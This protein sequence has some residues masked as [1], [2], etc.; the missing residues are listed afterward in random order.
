MPDLNRHSDKPSSLHRLRADASASAD[1]LRSF[2][3]QTRGKSP[4]E[5]IGL[6]AQSNLVVATMQAALACS[7]L[8]LVLTLVPYAL[9]QR[10]DTPQ[11][12][13][14]AAVQ[15]ETPAVTPTAAEPAK[16]AKTTTPEKP[17]TTDPAK[18]AD[19]LGEG[20]TKTGPA[21]EPKIDINDLLDK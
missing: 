10:T 5:V 13:P 12:T 11:A 2:L 16:V 3:H 14:A 6:V 20:G 17:P 18:V 15:P 7:V 19:V 9:S 4:A 8:V 21:S 1:E